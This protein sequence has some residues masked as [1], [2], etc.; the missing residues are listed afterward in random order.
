[1]FQSYNLLPQDFLSIF[2]EFP[3]IISKS[4]LFCFILRVVG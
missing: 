4:F 3:L 2:I 1:M